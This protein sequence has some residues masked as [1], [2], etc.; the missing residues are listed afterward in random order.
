FGVVVSCLHV[1]GSLVA[2]LECRAGPDGPITAPR[3]V[4]AVDCADTTI[5]GAAAIQHISASRILMEIGVVVRLVAAHC[6]N[7]ETVGDINVCANFTSPFFITSVVSCHTG[8]RA[9][10][11]SIL[12]AA[13][14][15]RHVVIDNAV[16]VDVNLV[17]L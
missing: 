7:R 3:A 2:S 10:T 11:A 4:E 5:R 1:E 16:V 12:Q 8:D 9:P 13:N 6:P 15:M 17:A 14:N